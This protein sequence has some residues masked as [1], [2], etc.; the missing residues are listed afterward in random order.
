MYHS[1]KLYMLIMQKTCASSVFVIE[2]LY[3]KA[4]N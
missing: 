2:C 3:D 4:N 1:N